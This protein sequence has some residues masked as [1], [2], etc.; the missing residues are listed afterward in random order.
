MSVH[1]AF[2]IDDVEEYAHRIGAY[3]QDTRNGMQELAARLQE[4]GGAEWHGATFMKCESD[5][6]EVL[7]VVLQSMDR[8]ENEL[9]PWLLLKVSQA[10][11]LEQD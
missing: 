4:L 6:N 10:R 2:P 5:L 9:V 1:V 3:A 8:L 7:A 11:E